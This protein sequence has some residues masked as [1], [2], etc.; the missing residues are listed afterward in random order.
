MN[1]AIIRK[2]TLRALLYGVFGFST[3]FAT[4]ISAEPITLSNAPLQASGKAQPNLMILLDSSGSMDDRLDS[5]ERRLDVAKAA[6]TDV[7]R[8]LGDIRVGLARFDYE[9]GAEILKGLTSISESGARSDLITKIGGIRAE[10]WTPLAESMADIGRYFVE[11]YDDRFVTI[12][13]GTEDEESVLAREVLANQPQYSSVPKPTAADPAIQYYCQKNF[14]LTLT[15]GLPTYDQNVSDY[16]EDYDGDCSGDNSGNCSSY[17]KKHSGYTYESRRNRPSDYLDDV[18]DALYDIDWRPDLT[19]P[20]DPDHKNNITSYF[21]G[22]ADSDLA[23]NQLLKDAGSQGGGSYKYASNSAEL[24]TSFNE[25]IDAISN[26]IGTQSSVSFNS[27]SLDTGSVI[28]SAKFDTSDFSGRLYARYMDPETGRISS[29]AWEAAEKLADESSSSR[30]IITYLDGS[31][32]PFTESE[33]DE[34]SGAPSYTITVR[35]RGEVGEENISLNVG[36]TAIGSWTLSKGYREF[37]ATTNNTSG[38]IQ[39]EFTNDVGERDV[40]V[41]YI[42]IDG[43]TLQAEEQSENTGVWGNGGCG[44]GG[45]SEW[46]HCNGYIEFCSIAGCE[47]AD[48]TPQRADLRVDDHTG[49]VDDQWD[50]RLDYIRGDTSKDSLDGFRPRGEFTSGSAAGSEILLGDIVHSTP[51]YVGEPELNWPAEFGGNNHSDSYAQFK[52]DEEDRTP[53]VY[54]GANDGMLHGFNADTGEETFAYIPSMVL[55]DERYQG[56]HA[57]TSTTYPH[58]YYVDLTPAVSDVYIDPDGGNSESWRTVLVGGLRGGGKGYFALD[59]TD[60]ANLEEDKADDVVL[61]EFDG[62]DDTGRANLGYGYSEAQVAKLNNGKWAVIFGNGY[63][64]DNGVAGLFIVYLED[65]ADGEWSADDWE[66][67]STGSGSE[68][69]RK[70]G[71]SSP[72]LIDLNGDRVVDRVYAGDLM[73]DMWAFDLSGD[74]END[75]GVADN[76]PLF[77]ASGATSEPSQAIMAAPLVARNTAVSNGSDPNVLVMFGTGQYLNTGDLTDDDAGAFYAVWDNGTTNVTESD[78]AE[79]TLTDDGVGR[80]IQSGD[81]IDWSEHH[82]WK[83]TLDSGS[84]SYAGERVITAPTLRRNT[85]FFSTVYPNPQPCASSGKGYLMG[86]DF[87]T[88]KAGEDA[89]ADINND[90]EINSDDEGYVGKEFGDDCTGDNCDGDDDSNSDDD[91]GMPGQSGFIGDVRCTPGSNGDVICDDIDVGDEEREGRLS[92]EEFAPR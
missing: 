12:H 43:T 24:V 89:V 45:S 87:R 59:V 54:V 36:G 64:S 86:F 76:K 16:L 3:T 58:N 8:G 46:L 62:G 48:V 19:D 77:K 52:I 85:L 41:D 66:F 57:F 4:C 35:A 71:L 33:L 72:R 6:A 53:M 13:P 49:T 30:E 81:D 15:D 22:F 47:L 29:T 38:K 56:L 92:W 91:P 23:N 25:A 9:H 42:Q 5:G 55:S 68:N 31:G 20:N 79:R 51:I 34:I 27:T 74:S 2:N 88:G 65:G 83:M 67:I 32:V 61:W 7:V 75:W 26:S 21:I 80:K 70:N 73:G 37:T 84:G 60:P 14:I 28:Y 90:G 63:N 1:R 78:L 18:A 50:D 40:Q 10:D 17:D 44:T 39:V 82:G 69:D 11:G